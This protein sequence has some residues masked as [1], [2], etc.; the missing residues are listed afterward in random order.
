MEN[1]HFKKVPLKS[2]TIRQVTRQSSITWKW[3]LDDLPID[4]NLNWWL[5]HRSYKIS[6]FHPSP[7]E[8]SPEKKGMA[9]ELVP[10]SKMDYPMDS[11]E[12]LGKSSNI[13]TFPN[14]PSGSMRIT[15]DEGKKKYPIEV[16]FEHH[17]ATKINR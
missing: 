3:F 13:G 1:H 8:A 17:D 14:H 16:G 7:S 12:M 10:N 9:H 11:W 6:W 4:L 15:T 5:S 2:T